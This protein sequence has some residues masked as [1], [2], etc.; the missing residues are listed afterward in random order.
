MV[1]A[2]R[3]LRQLTSACV[4][5]VWCASVAGCAASAAEAARHRMVSDTGGYALRL[6]IK[7]PRTNQFE[8][9]EVDRQGYACHAGGQAAL[10]GEVKYR[11]PLSPQ[12][13]QAF[14]DAMTECPWVQGKPDDRG[15]DKA[16]PITEVTL[17]LPGGT[18]RSFR[19][20]GEQPQ[21]EAFL[22]ILRP[23]VADRHKPILDR[24]PEATEGPKPAAEQAKPATGG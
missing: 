19:L 16:E 14:R 22:K 17:R 10:D 18:E 2:N 20:R 23:E 21:V 9:Y 24:L 11:R 3:L 4:A 8:L 13:A 7:R 1:Q 6:Q 15:P 12:G 5:M